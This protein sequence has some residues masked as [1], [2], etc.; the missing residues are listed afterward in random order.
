MIGIDPAAHNFLRFLWVKDP[1]KLFY[2]LIHLQFTRLV[3][4]LHPSPG[5]LGSVLAHHIKKF[6]AEFP[7]LTKKLRDSFY[8]DDL[9]TRASDVQGALTFACNPRRL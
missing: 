4:G 5:I 1:C 8:E 7:E 2:E 6:D 9:I 3:F